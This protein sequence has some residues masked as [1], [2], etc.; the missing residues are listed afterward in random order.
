[1]AN[2][3]GVIGHVEIDGFPVIYRYVDAPP[4]DDKR[5][6]LPWLTVIA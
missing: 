5:A 3:D 6:R 1:M 4:T 2:G